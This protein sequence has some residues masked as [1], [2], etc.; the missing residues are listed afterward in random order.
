MF[1]CAGV[2]GQCGKC[3]ERVPAGSKMVRKPEKMSFPEDFSHQPREG[4]GIAVDIGT[5]TVAGILWDRAGGK[6]LAACARTNPQNEYGMDVISRVSFCGGSPEK[7]DILRKGILDCIKDIIR[8]LREDASETGEISRMCIC[9]NTAM[10]HVF[11]GYPPASLARSPFLPAYEGTLRLAAPELFPEENCFGEAVLIPNI[12]G[13][14][15][16][17]IT[18]GI[19]AARLAQKEKLTLY[20]DIGTNGEIVLAEGGC[21]FTCST[22]A[23]PAFEG[24]SILH[25]MRAAEGAIE[26]VEI[27]ENAVLLQTIGDSMPRG[28]CG[29]GLLDAVSGLVQQGI[30]NK[31]GRILS[32]QA[33]EKNGF[34]KGICQRILERKEGRSFALVLKE[35]GESIVLTQ[36]DIRETQMAKGAIRA[37][38]RVLLSRAGREEKDLDEILIAGAF[39]SYIDKSSAI[40]TGLL[41]PV[42][43]E[44]IRF[45]GNAAGVGVSMTLLSEEELSSAEKLAKEIQHVELAED[46]DF[47][48]LYMA[49]MGF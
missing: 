32:R 21:V 6:R 24:A 49:S 18:A 12:A 7:L 33:A 26:K 29:S 34:S 37:G 46:K 3:K 28:I 42:S 27:R 13:H 19:L 25:G 35:N 10:S 45:L 15:G 8:Q 41:P 31:K 38:I 36:S 23:G 16:G 44:R 5:T 40:A 47:L 9:G 30:V 11:A 17:D 48:K 20:I 39:G 22:A 14:V 2:C 4:L 43:E 1:R